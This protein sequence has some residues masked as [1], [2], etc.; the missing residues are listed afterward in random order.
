MVKQNR[1]GQPARGTLFFRIVNVNRSLTQNTHQ[2]TIVHKHLSRQREI[3]S[4]HLHTHTHTQSHARTHTHARADT[5]THTQTGSYLR[6]KPPLMAICSRSSITRA[7]GWLFTTPSWFA[8]QAWPPPLILPHTHFSQG[9]S[10]CYT[11]CLCLCICTCTCMCV[12]LF[13]CSWMYEWLNVLWVWK[14]V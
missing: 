7:P 10:V 9:Q 1:N 14:K 11:V 3:A 6:M 8:P 12:N 13:T 5:H 2:H 4:T